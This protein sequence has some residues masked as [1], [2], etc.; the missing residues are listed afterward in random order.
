[1]Q[2]QPLLTVILPAFNEA[3]VIGEVITE[4]RNAISCR[5]V[6]VDDGSSDATVE[7]ARMQNVTVISHLLNRGAGA[8]CMTGISLAKKM[9]WQYIAFLDADGQHIATD[10]QALQTCMRETAADLVIG[11]RFMHAENNIPRIRRLFNT[12]ANILT[13]TFCK[14]RYSDTQ[15]GFRLLN[16]Q[17]I[18]MIVLFQDD[19][20]YCSEMIIQAEQAD[21]KIAECP[22]AVR[23]TEY[24]MS[25]GQDFQ[26]GV[27]TAFHFMWKLIFK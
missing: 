12:I 8:A 6:V 23:Y 5:I 4:I 19:F 11:S 7:Q 18:E 10:L 26:V 25:K 27:M 24:S 20:S 2:D 13:N 3:E 17:A 16:R 1:M 22:I 15:S 9:N 21:L 14:Y